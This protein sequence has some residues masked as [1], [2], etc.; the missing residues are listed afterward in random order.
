MMPMLQP[1]DVSS[2]QDRS[3]WAR[4]GA[5]LLGA[6]VLFLCAVAVKWVAG[7]KTRE[8]PSSEHSEERRRKGAPE[9]R[10]IV[11]MPAQL[12]RQ[13]APRSES[14]PQ[15]IS[16]LALAFQ[17]G[18]NNIFFDEAAFLSRFAQGGRRRIDAVA[19][20]LRRLDGL[21]TLPSDTRFMESKPKVFKE[22]MAMIDLL[23]GY[24]H[25]DI[26]MDSRKAAL[27]ALTELA[28]SSIPHS[29]SAATK[30]ALL[31]EK[32]DSILLLAH[33]DKEQALSAIAQLTNSQLK[34]QLLPAIATGLRMGGMDEK[35]ALELVSN[36]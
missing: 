8:A 36:L 16:E 2:K 19:D 21:A 27:D 17:E 34:L 12:I 30:K 35:Q 18:Q 29:A 6:A 24:L 15:A 23:A 22:R 3:P 5:L 7:K 33:F 32:Y 10:P 25:H 1:C 26:G 14:E 28:R 13:W 11:I 20:E 9:E 4:M 31:S